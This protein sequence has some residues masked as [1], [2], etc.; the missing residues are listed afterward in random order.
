MDTFFYFR[1]CW[2]RNK[3]QFK[4]SPAP[5]LRETEDWKHSLIQAI[6]QSGVV[7]DTWDVNQADYGLTWNSVVGKYQL[8]VTES[9]RNRLMGS[10][11]LEKSDRVDVREMTGYFAME[12]LTGDVWNDL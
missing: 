1:V 2:S 12:P 8:H 4:T 6:E 3:L 9:N 11:S 7:L 5:L 10:K